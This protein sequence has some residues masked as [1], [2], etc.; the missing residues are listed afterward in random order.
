MTDSS[1]PEVA[2]ARKLMAGI[3]A[4]K[5]VPTERGE[6]KKPATRKKRNN[7]KKPA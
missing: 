2:A 3:L 6:G 7:R 5:P 1:D 4:D